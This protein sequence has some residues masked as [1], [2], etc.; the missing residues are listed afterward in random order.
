MSKISVDNL[1][2]LTSNIITMASGQVLYTPGS[3]IQV[4]TAYKTD[5]QTISSG[6]TGAF[7]DLTGLSISITP[8]R[9]SSKIL[10][11]WSV[12][13]GGG[14]DATHGYVR[15][16]RG[17]TNLGLADTSGSKTS[18]VSIVVNTSIGGQTLVNSGHY[19]D[20]PVT[21]A[22][23]TYKLTGAAGAGA[24]YVNRSS[25][26]TDLANYDGRGTSSFV[27]MEIAA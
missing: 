27:I 26:D 22:L 17:S 12:N 7:V 19:L 15:L 2:G 21:T 25:R 20:S 24:L 4:L 13:Y 1:Q 14:A 16:V 8:K 18:A 9:T 23:T 11:Q 5:T 10:C 3:I 6:S